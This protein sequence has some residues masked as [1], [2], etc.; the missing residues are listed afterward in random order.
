MSYARYV[1]NP[2][3]LIV[4]SRNILSYLIESL[5][6]TFVLK[7]AME[8][9]FLLN[10]GQKFMQNFVIINFVWS[11]S[12]NYVPL[13]N[14]KQLSAWFLYILILNQI[15]IF[16][17]PIIHYVQNF[18]I[19]VRIQFGHYTMSIWSNVSHSVT[20]KYLWDILQFDQIGKENRKTWYPMSIV[21]MKMQGQKNQLV[22]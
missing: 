6:K 18:R 22:W 7:N 9:V 3:D 5:K 15:N 8:H 13:F 11:L 19:R 12:Y 2:E 1:Q 14:K 16:S 21:Y 17:Q 10:N 4:T 20:D